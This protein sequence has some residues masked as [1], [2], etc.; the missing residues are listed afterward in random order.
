MCGLGGVPV[1]GRVQV[2]RRARGSDSAQLVAGL[3]GRGTEGASNAVDEWVA[4]GA[5]EAEAAR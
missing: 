5:Q 2:A 4:G 3:R 1:L